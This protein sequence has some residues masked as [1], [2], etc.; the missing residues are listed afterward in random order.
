MGCDI[1]AGMNDVL[2]GLV[3]MAVVIII[4]GVCCYGTFD[5]LRT[6]RV[7]VKRNT[8]TRLGD[9]FNYWFSV[10]ALIGSGIGATSVAIWMVWLWL[11]G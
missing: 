2:F 10:V 3:G 6:G 5:A 7:V 1:I 9:P 4:I 8:F 11:F